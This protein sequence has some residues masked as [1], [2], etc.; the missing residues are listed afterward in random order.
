MVR[1][2]SVEMEDDIDWVTADPL[3]LGSFREE[4]P[5]GDSEFWKGEALLED[6][7]KTSG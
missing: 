1:N 4:D 5:E 7:M 2:G 3:V 6:V